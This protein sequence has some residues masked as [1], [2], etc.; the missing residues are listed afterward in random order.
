MS[1]YVTEVPRHVRGPL[2]GANHFWTRLMSGPSCQELVHQNL[3]P[4]DH[5]KWMPSEHVTSYS[6]KPWNRP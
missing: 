2:G 4:R 3:S 5:V 1:P 6:W